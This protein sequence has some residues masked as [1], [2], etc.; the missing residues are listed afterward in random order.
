MKILSTAL[1]CALLGG[2]A[3][4]PDE[5]YSADA[6]PFESVPMTRPVSAPL[7]ASHALLGGFSPGA[8]AALGDPRTYMDSPAPNLQKLSSRYGY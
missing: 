5:D 7:G 1:A 8:N 6:A 2:C 3:T 4:F